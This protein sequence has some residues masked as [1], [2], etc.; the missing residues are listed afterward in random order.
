MLFGLA[1][2]WLLVVALALGIAWYLGKSMVQ[3]TSVAHL[4]YETTMLADE[5]TQEVQSRISAL[6]HVANVAD[7]PDV[8][9][10]L[11]RQ[12][13]HNDALLEWFEGVV[14][15]DADGNLKADWPVLEERRGFNIS[16]REYFRMIKGT[17]SPYVSEPLIGQ[18]SRVPLVLI[19]VPRHDDSGDFAGM[20]GGVMSLDSGELFTRLDRQVRRGSY[21][22]I[23][24]ASGKVLYHP[25]QAKIMADSDVFSDNAALVNAMYGWE[26]EAVGE[27]YRGKRGLQLY[28]QVWPA[29]W[30]VG[31]FITLEEIRAPLAGFIRQLWWVWGLMGLCMLPLLWWV[32]GGMLKPL[33]YLQ[34]QMGEVGRA[35]RERIELGSE[36]NEFQD[37]AGTFN[38]VEAERKAL[39][40]DLKER[41]AFLDEMLN[42]TPEGMFVANLDGDITYMNPALLAMLGLSSTITTARWLSHVH[43]DDRDGIV[44]LW[45]ESLAA[46]ND[47]V[48]QLRFIRSDGILLWLEIHSRFVV[49]SRGEQTLDLVGTMKD[50]TQSREQEALTRWEAEHDPL[51]GLLNRRG[52]ERRLD[53][54][55]AEYKKT[56]TPSALLMFDLDH[57][58]PINDRGGHALGDEML[59]RIARVLNLKVRRSDYAARQGGD[60]FAVLLPSC[61]LSQAQ[62]IA[63]ALRQAVADIVV[64]A[65]DSDFRVTLSM[66]VTAFSAGDQEVKEALAR[67]DTASYEA[68]AL[69]RNALIVSMPDE[70]DMPEQPD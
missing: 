8:S 5:I 27:L 26:G 68:K 57:F 16:H 37:I 9:A 19:G 45:R 25:D 34:Q 41:G 60:E 44:K 54:A 47:F 28:K 18:A 7:T 56:A 23:F 61:T 22:G 67:A 6:E 39:L 66:G 2:T 51:T 14:I 50:I 42:A 35:H 36:V 46:R 53:E 31:R 43:P 59:R 21:V 30:V 1:C 24:T 20:V 13:R 38:Q 11:Q 69:G 15:I 64:T 10:S 55:F 65:R 63:E 32:L 40:D 29:N 33:Y 62:P 70:N 48:L 52:F 3:E 4:R 17:G 12:L 58:K 49:L